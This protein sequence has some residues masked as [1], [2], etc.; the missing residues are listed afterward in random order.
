[1]M[2]QTAVQHVGARFI[3]TWNA[4]DMDEFALP[5]CVDADFVNVYGRVK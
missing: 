2:G 4:H 3:E 5:F 1:M